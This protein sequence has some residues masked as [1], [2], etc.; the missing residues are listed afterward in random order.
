MVSTSRSSQS[1]SSALGV[2]VISVKK[3]DRIGKVC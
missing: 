1:I 2:P 3:G